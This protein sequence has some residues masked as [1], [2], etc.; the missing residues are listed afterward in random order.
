MIRMV[1]VLN[2]EEITW[3]SQGRVCMLALF[4]P[5]TRHWKYFYLKTGFFKILFLIICLAWWENNWNQLFWKGAILKYL[6]CF[7]IW[8]FL[9]RYH[10]TFD[11]WKFPLWMILLNQYSLSTMCEKFQ[12]LLLFY[13]GAKSTKR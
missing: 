5:H 9:P 6:L 1:G 10:H 13:F 8:H 12:D 2:D 3:W 4:V 11:P 7:K